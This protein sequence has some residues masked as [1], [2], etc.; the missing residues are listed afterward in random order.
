M[1]FHIIF[2]IIGYILRIEGLLLL[3]PAL[4]GLI[5]QEKAAFSYLICA[6]L[7]ALV[8]TLMTIKK[9]KNQIF[10]AKEGF[11]SV[12]LSWIFLSLFGCLPFMLSGDIPRFAD[13]F[14]EMVSG[15]TTTGS[16]I[17]PDV[18]AMSHATLFWRSFSHW[19]GGMGILVFALS[20]LPLTGGATMHLMRAESPGPQVGKM[21]PKIRETSKILYIIYT[22]MTL[23][24][25]AILICLKM[26]IFDAITISLGTAGTGGFAVLNSGLASYSAACQYV[27][28]IFMIL[29][30][31]NFN[32][33]FLAIRRH[34]KQAFRCEEMRWYT[35]II[36]LSTAA[37]FLNTLHLFKNA[38]EA[39]RH[40]L[41]QVS[42]IITTTGFATTD[43]DLFPSTAKTILVLL[44]FIGAC[45]G[46]TGGGIKVS[47]IAI[48]IKSSYN[49]LTRIIH[50]RTVKKVQLEG[51][52]VEHS[53][54]RSVNTFLISYL[55]IFIISILIISLDNFDFTTNFTAVAATINNIGPGLQKIGPTSNFSG[56][57]D[58]S[59]FILSFDMLAGRLE[60]F[61]ILI[62]LYPG[63]W[64]RPFSFH[65]K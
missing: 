5:Y 13:A 17:L 30:G 54:L 56:F 3:F 34:F 16:S 33:Y 38:E 20:I 9:P 14:F 59:K 48:M 19:I 57:S 31:V 28:A 2:Y 50:P 61:P 32:V 46:S 8:G 44:M 7:A 39:F 64:Q 49:E 26:P 18:E 29:F 27:V 55:G 35:S 63:T 22:V 45:A 24:E 65:K 10:Y 37:I 51:K 4:T 60:I 40:S 42:S 15:F 43:F 23:I 62:L 6:A 52:A 12:A 58:L 41:F 25:M 21:V 1:N 36:A 11:V 47:R 53:T